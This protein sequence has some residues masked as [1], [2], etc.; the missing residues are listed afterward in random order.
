VLFFLLSA[1]VT[2]TYALFLVHIQ[3]RILD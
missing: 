1:P 2:C 3:G